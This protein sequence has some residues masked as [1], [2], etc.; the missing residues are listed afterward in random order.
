MNTNY[1]N[2]NLNVSILSPWTDR[3]L[4]P[5][6]KSMDFWNVSG[7]KCF[8]IAILTRSF[9]FS[10]QINIFYVFSNGMFIILTVKH[11]TWFPRKFFFS[12][13]LICFCCKSKLCPLCSWFICP[14]PFDFS[15]QTLKDHRA[16]TKYYKHQTWLVVFLPAIT[17][18][19]LYLSIC[20]RLIPF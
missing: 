3:P 1:F 13:Y 16:L 10:F 12:F 7:L 17:R 6:A 4:K 20:L 18:Q 14:K 9:F 2:R 8:H 15:L 19:V 5:P 11:Y